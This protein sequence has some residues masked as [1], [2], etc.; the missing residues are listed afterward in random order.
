MTSTTWGSN[1]M[2]AQRRNSPSAASA[3]ITAPY[4][5]RDV[6]EWYASQAVM[7]RAPSGMRVPAIPS[8]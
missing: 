3:P 7:I 8:G 4:V 5:R 2:P 1:C 6:I